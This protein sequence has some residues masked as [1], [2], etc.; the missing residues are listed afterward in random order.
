MSFSYPFSYAD[1]DYLIKRFSPADLD[2]LLVFCRTCELEGVH[3]NSSI[4]AM[5]LNQFEQE[6]WWLT[7]DLASNRVVSVAGVHPF[8]EFEKGAWRVMHRLATLREFR[9]R[10]GGFAKDQRSCF[11]WGRM[12]PFQVRYCQEHGANKIVFTTNCDPNDGDKNSLKQN[13]ICEKVFEKLGMAR[14]LGIHMVFGVQQ[15]VW[16]VLITDVYTKKP[17]RT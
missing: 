17:L 12:L 15:R 9:G 14:C 10:A 3:N 2:D 6:A 16:E 4:K 8:D 7:Y 1:Q 13:R 11:G 5:K